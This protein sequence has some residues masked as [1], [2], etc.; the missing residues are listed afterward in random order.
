MTTGHEALRLADALQ[1]HA[2]M[3]TRDE[4]AAML[5]KLAAEREADRAAMREAL[6]ALEQAK[7]FAHEAYHAAIN[8]SWYSGG[9]HKARQYEITALRNGIDHSYECIT[10][11]RQRLGQ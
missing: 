3:A 6:E 2:P 10:H 11:L 9:E 4:A 5:R 7:R 1:G 8:P